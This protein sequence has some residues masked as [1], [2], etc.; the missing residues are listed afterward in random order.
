MSRSATLAAILII[1]GVAANNFV[2]LQDLL[3]GQGSISLDSWK[4]YT[5][6][7]VSLGIVLLGLI[8]FLRAA[9]KR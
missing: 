8:L 4:A 2:Y 1:V 5:A 7:L 9:A 3:F 6:I